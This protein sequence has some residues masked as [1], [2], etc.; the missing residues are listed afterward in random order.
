MIHLRQT[1]R[2]M[3]FLCI[4][5]VSM[6]MI[7]PTTSWAQTNVRVQ[8]L[9]PLYIYPDDRWN[10]VANAASKVP[11]TVVI[12]PNSGPGTCPPGAAYIQ[13][14]NTLRN[15]GV[16]IVGYVPTTN[17]DRPINTVKADIDL[18]VQCFN[19]HGVFLDETATTLDKLSYYG[20]LYDYIRS[21]PNFN[22]VVLN[23]GTNINEQY[24]SRPA[25]D[26]SIIFESYST[27]WPGYDP[28]SYVSAYP[29]ERFAMLVHTTSDVNTMKS[30]V[31]L[32]LTRHIGYVYV[33]NDIM[34]NPWDTLPSYWT[35]FVD[36]LASING[37]SYLLWT[38]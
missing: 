30:H 5:V 12:N 20:E 37:L 33:T 15:A 21:K 8:I 27:E 7:Q 38:K 6:G 35:E 1:Y 13:G 26:I 4:S 19:I 2:Y 34:D 24:V 32:A 11:V 36:Y 18:Y 25:G 10:D 28:D 22:T 14:L 9:I 29:A 23:P 16:T 3:L 17:G 31:D